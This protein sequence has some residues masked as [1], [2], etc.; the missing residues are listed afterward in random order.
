M[1]RKDASP[2]LAYACFLFAGVAALALSLG[3]RLPVSSG[4]A[5]V[6]GFLVAIPLMLASLAA[7]GYGVF[8][9]ARLR[10]PSLLVLLAALSVLYVIQ[11]FGEFGPVG[12]RNAAPVVYGTSVVLACGLWFLVLRRRAG[13]KRAP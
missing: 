2:D 11:T 4:A 6:F 1:G 12:L 3:S 10:R 7:I 13:P 9:A 8:A 5:G